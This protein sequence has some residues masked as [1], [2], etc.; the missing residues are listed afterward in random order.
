M[1]HHRGDDFIGAV[2]PGLCAQQL[3]P[4][5]AATVSVAWA[6]TGLYWQLE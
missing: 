4:A 6:C 5:R 2:H 1:L 3:H